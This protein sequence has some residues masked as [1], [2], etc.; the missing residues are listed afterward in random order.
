ML[1]VPIL[2]NLIENLV[3]MSLIATSQRCMLKLA[4]CYVFYEIMSPPSYN[5]KYKTISCYVLIFLNLYS[6]YI[7]CRKPRPSNG[8][9]LE[10]A[11]RGERRTVHGGVEKGEI[12]KYLQM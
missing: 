7:T 8:D 5:Y 6:S 11:D 1:R 4:N 10:R 3:D 2:T 12:T 9:S